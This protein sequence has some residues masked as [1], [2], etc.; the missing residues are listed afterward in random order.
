MSND[1]RSKQFLRVLADDAEDSAQP[2]RQA[3]ETKAESE[4]PTVAMSM[5]QRV[6]GQLMRA[7]LHTQ[8]Y[9]CASRAQSEIIQSQL[10]TVPVIE[11]PARRDTFGAIALSSLYLL[12]RAGAADDEVC[13]VMPVDSYVDDA[14]FLKLQMLERALVASGSDLA[15]LGVRP[16]EAT[17]KFGYI[18]VVQEAVGAVG[19]G[20]AAELAARDWLAVDTFVEKPAKDVAATLISQGALWNCGVFCF[21]LGYIRA[22]LLAA[23]L[24]AAYDA[25]LEVFP[26]LPKRSFDYEVVEKA[27]RIVVIS[28]DGMWKDLG[29]WGALTEEMGQTFVG[30]GE[31]LACEGTHVINELGIPLIAMG[32]HDAVIVATPDGI[33]VADKGMSAGIKN[34]VGRH[35][36][37]PMFEERRWGMYRVLD[38]QKL[39]DGTEVLTKCIDMFPDRMLSY[40]KHMKRGEVWTFIEGEGEIALDGRIISVAAGDVVRVYRDQ[41]HAIRA[42]TPLKFIEVQRGDVLIEED[43]IRLHESW[44]EIVRHFASGVL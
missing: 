6:W 16:T 3:T 22:A 7:G 20:T 1:G 43:I 15:L 23:G 4:I 17:S 40:Q 33:L 14:Y 21:R 29:T 32:V 11:E 42:I 18:R 25:L 5:L 44:D 27:E 12:D 26:T 19:L 34:V 41:W 37:R 10:G 24:P 35:E 36:G 28:Y 9:V 8:A 31:A 13:V 30:K 38:Y 2:Q 39:D